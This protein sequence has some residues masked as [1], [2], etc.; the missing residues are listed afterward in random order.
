MIGFWALFARNCER[1]EPVR[2]FMAACEATLPEGASVGG[3]SGVGLT[4]GLSN[5]RFAHL[6]GIYSPEFRC[7]NTHEA[8]E[9]LKNVPEKRF[10]YW[11]VD[12]TRECSFATGMWRD[13]LWGPQA[14]VGPNGFE[15]RRADW[16]GYD[17]AVRAPDGGGRRLVARVDVGWPKDERAVDYRVFDRYARRPFEPFIQLGELRGR[18]IVEAGRLVFGGDEMTVPLQAGHDAMVVMRT[19]PHVTAV[20][21]DGMSRDTVSGSFG[22]KI[23]LNVQIGSDG[24]P[25]PVELDCPTNGFADVAFRIPGSAISSSS[26]RVAFL[27]DHIACAYWFYQ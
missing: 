18:K 2:H 3:F 26:P 5:R 13:V 4:Y 1:M 9:E 20:L 11:L 15:L 17:A 19:L 8:V 10:D 7:P 21:S 22:P 25:F 16:S 14:L 12:V 23:R 6:T 27:G 24:M